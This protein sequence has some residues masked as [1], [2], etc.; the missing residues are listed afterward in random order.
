MQAYELIKRGATFTDRQHEEKARC[1]DAH[2]HDKAAECAHEE[3]MAQVKA[4]QAEHMQALEMK[5]A[6]LKLKLLDH[7]LEL[8]KVRSGGNVCSSSSS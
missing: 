6:E 7:K 2:S 4:E 3:R 1:H 8:A 5:M